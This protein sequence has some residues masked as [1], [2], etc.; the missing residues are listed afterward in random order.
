MS[1]TIW[2]STPSSSAKVR[3]GILAFSG[4][5]P[6]RSTTPT[7]AAAEGGA[8]DPVGFDA[9]ASPA[10]DVA[11]SPGTP[12][13]AA[14]P[15]TPTTDPPGTATSTPVAAPP[16]VTDDDLRVLHELKT[17]RLIGASVGCV[18]RIAGVDDERAAALRG[19]AADLGVLF[20]VVDDIL[21]VTGTDQDLGKPQGS[22]ERHGKRTY[23]TEYGLEGARSMATDLHDAASTAL[24]SA[25]PSVG[26][27]DLHTLTAFIHTRTN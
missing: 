12:S 18:L 16:V 26:A 8:G 20:Q 27:E 25:V 23:V 17:G 10:D 19:F 22:D 21:D 4:T 7:L 14:S 15:G 9:A 11:P 13:P 5:P 2:N 6:N 1:S 3:Y 24:R